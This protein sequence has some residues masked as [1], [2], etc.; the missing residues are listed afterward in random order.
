MTTYQDFP[1]GMRSVADGMAERACYF[2]RWDASFPDFKQIDGLS[3]PI[4]VLLA[5]L[6]Y[7]E[8]ELKSFPR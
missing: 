4:F 8:G 6:M 5:R 2:G 7:L 3:V 1:G